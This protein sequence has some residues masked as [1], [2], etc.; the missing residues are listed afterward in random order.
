MCGRGR[1]GPPEISRAPWRDSGA[2][3]RLNGPNAAAPRR[4]AGGPAY[5]PPFFPALRRAAD[6]RTRAAWT[7]RLSGSARYLRMYSRM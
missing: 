2:P 6:A 4:Q 7:A 3:P 1:A 5:R